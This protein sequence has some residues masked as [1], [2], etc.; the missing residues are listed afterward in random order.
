LAKPL[1]YLNGFY[2]Y[3][4]SAFATS[5]LIDTEVFTF[6]NAAVAGDGDRSRPLYLGD[7]IPTTQSAG[8][9]LRQGMS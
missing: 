5:W 7:G 2:L 3:T 8:S 4:D 9:N 1:F 6:A